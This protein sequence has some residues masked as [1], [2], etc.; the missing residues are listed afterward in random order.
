MVD[1]QLKVLV[2]WPGSYVG[3]RLTRE[4]LGH[5]DVRLRLLVKDARQMSEVVHGDVEV[6][7]GD[8]L[9]DELLARAVEGINVAY[10]PLRFLGTDSHFGEL[11]RAFAQKFLDACVAA[12]VKR[13]IYLGFPSMGSTGNEFVDTMDDVGRILSSEPRMIETVCLKAG[14]VIGSGSILFEVLRNLVQKSP[15]LV[16]P[17]WMETKVST[18][19]IADLLKYLVLA[20][21]CDMR[22]SKVVDIGLHTMSV[23]EMLVATARVMGLTRI[24][25]PIP[26]EA[27]RLSSIIL[28]LTSPFPFSL[29]SLLIGILK[30]GTREQIPKTLKNEPRR[31]QGISPIPFEMA[32][33]RA[34]DAIAREQVLS[35]WTDSVAGISYA[36]DEQELGKSVFRDIKTR[37]FG[38][39]HVQKIFQ[40]VTSIGGQRGWFSFDILWRIRGF[41]DKMTGGFGTSV[42]R[43]GESELR[44][45]DLLDVWKVVDLQ[46]NRRLLLEAQM[47][48]F[49]RAWLEFRIEGS[50]LTQT[51]YHYP[52]GLMGRVYWYAMLPFHAFIFKDMIESIVQRAR[53]L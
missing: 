44:I 26:F 25:V 2:V 14:F 16:I 42:G 13:I 52:K 12:G 24:V 34:I 32:I 6:V 18:I 15:I 20:R 36:D 8:A 31:F 10:F 3:R 23:R 22:G 30:T 29:A 4:F 28:M 53:S 1:G 41:L 49:G 5:M 47:K 37:H 43:R 51:A 9:H 33:E 46:E 19:G 7:E 27:R 35:R 50:T 38:D 11:S 40:A 17:R 45:G 39:T 48:V 21:N